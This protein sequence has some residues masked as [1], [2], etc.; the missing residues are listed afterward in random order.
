MKQILF[1]TDFSKTAQNA[2]SFAIDL[3]NR[4]GSQ[5]TLLHAYQI[6]KT[7]TTLINMEPYII[8][9]AEQ[10]MNRWLQQIQPEL[11]NGATLA[12][13]IFNST[14]TDA[15]KS[16]TKEQGF[17]LIIMG[18]EGANSMV[19]ALI[20]TH[21]NSVIKNTTLP[22]LVIPSGVAFRPFQTIVLAVDEIESF[23]IE[24]LKPFVNIA[25]NY[26]SM[27]RV[28]HKD[29]ANDGLNTA[30]DAYLEGIDRSYHYEL[31]TDNL[32]ESLHDFVAE[33]DANLLCMI[34]RQ[35]T[36][37]ENVF[38]DSATSQEAFTAKVP[39]LLLHDM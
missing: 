21:T 31:D 9:D 10:D 15:I 5:L 7:A 26:A 38:H 16:V 37:L 14:I 20:G 36:F 3:A 17:D 19:E 34:R 28:Y 8:E 18:T 25:H 32:M 12:S 39:L 6:H 1:P 4:F 29:E 23:Q 24:T 13:K 35:R 27:V 30:I 11:E 22:V 33:Y 2:L